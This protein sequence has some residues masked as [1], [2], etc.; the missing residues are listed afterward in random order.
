MNRHQHGLVPRRLD[1]LG[2]VGAD[3]RDLPFVQPRQTG[4][5][6]A[7]LRD[8]VRHAGLVPDAAAAGPQQHR[9][10]GPHPHTLATLGLLEIVG[11]HTLPR[12]QP[13]HIADPRDVQ[14]D[15]TRDDPV[16]R[17]RDGRPR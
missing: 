8:V 17:R 11:K 2:G 7:G 9:I 4:R 14:Q 10:A 5:V 3:Q 6:P 1:V 12:F 15:T 16:R 13:R